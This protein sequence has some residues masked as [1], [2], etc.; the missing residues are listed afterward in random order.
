MGGGGGGRG[1]FNKANK[2]DLNKSIIQRKSYA[3]SSAIRQKGALATTTE[4]ATRTSSQ[5]INSCYCN[6]FQVFQAF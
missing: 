1:W 4:T 5:N 3:R 2:M 6:H